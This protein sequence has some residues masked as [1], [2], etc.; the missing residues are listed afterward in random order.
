MT[1]IGNRSRGRSVSMNK[2]KIIFKLCALS[3][4]ALNCIILPVLA[5]EEDTRDKHKGLQQPVI[6]KP[7]TT[8][9]G[10]KDGLS[11]NFYIGA[12]EGYDNNVYL[13]SSRKGDIFDQVMADAVFRYRLNDRLNIKARY[14]LTSLT[15][16][17][18]TDV[19]MFDNQVSASLE[20]YPQ[21]RLKFEAGYIVDFVDY[22]KG[23]G[24]DFIMDG[25]F[26]GLR[27]YID[28][29]SYIGGIYQ[30]N[31]Y[32]Y[33]SRKTRDISN[34]VAGITREDK[35]NTVIAEFATYMGELFVKVKN[36]YFWNDSNDQYLDFYDYNSQRIGLYTA[37][38][39]TEKLALLLSGGYQ[40]K[41]FKS[42]TTIKDPAKKE[43][44]NIMMLGG[45]VCY[46]I[47]P[48]CSISINYSY[49]QNYSNDPMQ[50][51]SGGIGTIGVNIYI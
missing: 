48:A 20:Y 2:M 1:V 41:D 17:R 18:F 38:P 12:S 26:A 33:R 31:T 16:H 6:Q 49:R 5:D 8:A 40:R 21:N 28:K 25:P 19:N 34:Q 36:T 44:D 32:D 15:Y 35:R 3:Y 4:L 43:H 39:V 51:Y 23:S 50:E 47:L 29:R 9:S 42:R 22:L 30:Y 11:Y 24:S 37:Y 14:D 45:G 7:A 46:K 27:Y 13:N 10:V